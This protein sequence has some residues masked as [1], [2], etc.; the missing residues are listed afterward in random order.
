MRT[1]R[2]L[3]LGAVV[4]ALIVGACTP[5]GGGSSP[6]ATEAVAEKPPVSIGSAGFYEAAVVA[7][8][9]AQALEANGYEVERHLELG[10]RDVVHAAYDSGEINLWPEYLGG[11]GTFIG[12]E[13]DP[14]PQTAWDN[15]QDA[16]AER[17]LVAFDYSPGSDSDGF[18]VTQETADE[19][20]L[21]TLTD[22]AAVADQ[23]VWGLAPGCA[24]NP[25]CGPG[26]NE[27]YGID[28]T[29]LEV[30]TLTPCS[31]EMA[32]ALNADAIQVAQV[33]TTQ[34]DI[35]TFNLVVLE[36]DGGLQPAQNM[37]PVASQEL[38]DAAPDDFAETLNEVTALLTNEV[39]IGLGVQYVNEQMSFEDIASQFL[40]DNGL[41]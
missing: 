33:C 41:N 25:V 28:I 26:L 1:H 16:L 36:D 17:G 5:G 19:H 8:I 38:A 7:E 2:T 23:F 27:I 14:D 20:G 21:E 32:Q 39:L 9:Y 11:L 31:T 40:S 10:E 6:A 37:V 24:E 29:Q 3:A 12:A 22:L 18:A 34:P 15:M 30:E 13:G 35:Q 4:L